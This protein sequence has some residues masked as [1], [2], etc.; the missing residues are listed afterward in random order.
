M[1]LT[2]RRQPSFSGIGV[3]GEQLGGDDP[4]AR[5]ARHHI[6]KGAAATDP[7][8]SVQIHFVPAWGIDAHRLVPI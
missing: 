5:L 3:L 6:G 4:P 7:A 1:M 2:G 8:A